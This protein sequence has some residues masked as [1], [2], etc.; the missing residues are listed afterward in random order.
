MGSGLHIK[1]MVENRFG[2]CHIYDLDSILEAGL[3]WKR[4][5]VGLER[6]RALNSPILEEAGNKNSSF[7]VGQGEPLH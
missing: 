5:S 3:Q 4:R 2:V 6:I 1:L 7:K